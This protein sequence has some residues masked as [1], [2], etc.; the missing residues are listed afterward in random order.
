MASRWPRIATASVVLMAGI[1]V[2]SNDARAD[3]IGKVQICHFPPGNPDNFHTLTVGAPAVPAHL[4]HGDFLGACGSNCQL[5]CD[6]GNPCTV[7]PCDPNTGACLPHRL[8]DCD[9]GNFCTTDLCNPSTGGCENSLRNGNCDDLDS[10]TQDDV[11]V[12]GRCMGTSIPGC[13]T[14]AADCDD[15]NPCTNDTCADGRC[16]HS[17]V[18]CDDGN[19][20]TADTCNPTD[21][22]CVFAPIF[23]DDGDPCTADSCDPANGC[24]NQPISCQCTLGSAEG[25]PA[26][27]AL[28]PCCDQGMQCGA[29]GSC[30]SFCIDRGG[31]CSGET[32][33]CCSGLSCVLGIC[34]ACLSESMACDGT[35][36]CCTGLACDPAQGMCQPE[37][38]R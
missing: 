31:A 24:T 26:C 18:L 20:C 28:L 2:L 37:I 10:C 32:N 17:D 8:V 19:A 1:G 29:D 21:G 34:D 16:Q 27:S 14:S 23:C 5:L 35:Q 22:A 4:A 12:Q 3:A 33:I 6:D 36:P 15:L 38:L 13:C 7:D 11:C 9:D 30:H 25:D